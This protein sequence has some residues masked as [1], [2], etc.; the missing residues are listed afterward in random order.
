MNHCQ[1]ITFHDVN[2]AGMKI[3]CLSER[4]TSYQLRYG[5]GNKKSRTLEMRSIKES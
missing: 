5:Q 3:T 1:S 4:C 2:K